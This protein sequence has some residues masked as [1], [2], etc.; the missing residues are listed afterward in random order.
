VVSEDIKPF[1]NESKTNENIKLT[2]MIIA[3]MSSFLTPFTASSVNIAFPSINR[4]LTMSA[5]SLSWVATAY[6]LAA[7]MF[8]VPFGRVADIKDRKRVFFY[9]VAIDA[10]GVDFVC[11]IQGPH[12]GDRYSD[13]IRT[14]R[15]GDFMVW[16]RECSVP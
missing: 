8:L 1:E 14:R 3:A 6:L 15:K 5:V 10:V 13:H 2:V 7:A 16:A 9:G 11:H 4:E 12:R